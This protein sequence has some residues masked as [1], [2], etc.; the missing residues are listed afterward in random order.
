MSRPSGSGN[1]HRMPCTVGSAASAAMVS[2]TCAW[3][4]VAGRSVW[5]DTMPASPAFFCLEL[6]YDRLGLSSP[7]STVARHTWGLPAASIVARDLGDELLAEARA[8][9]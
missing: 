2:F 9:P 1:W 4:A 8:R 3:L 6:M 5:R 7:T